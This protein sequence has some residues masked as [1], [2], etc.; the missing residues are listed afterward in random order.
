MGKQG[1]MMGMK[2]MMKQRMMYMMSRMM[3]NAKY[4]KASGPDDM[5]GNVPDQLMENPMRQSCDGVSYLRNQI[6]KTWSNF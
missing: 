3:Y 6:F 4:F 5:C 2:G 1:G